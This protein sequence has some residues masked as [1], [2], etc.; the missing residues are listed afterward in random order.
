MNIVGLLRRIRCMNVCGLVYQ[1]N[2]KIIISMTVSSI[3]YIS[4]PDNVVGPFGR[5]CR[6]KVRLFVYH[7]NTG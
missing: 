1:K 7:K 2:C 6:M 3:S 4:G 5:A